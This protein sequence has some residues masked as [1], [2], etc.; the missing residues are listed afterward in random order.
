MSFVRYIFYFIILTITLVF[1]STFFELIQLVGIKPNA[2]LITVMSIAYIR[3]EKEGFI[4]GFTAGLMQDCFF[5]TYVGSNVFL[6][7]LLGYFGGILCKSFYKEN[8]FIAVG[9]IMAAS[10][11]Y[12]FSYYVIN[13]LLR[14][15]TDLAYFMEKLI[16]PEAV[17]DGLAALLL[18]NILFTFNEWLEDRER[19]KRKVF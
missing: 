15:Y 8:F 17:Y 4:T 1:Q 5:C 6:Y 10:I 12:N 14:G 3:G 9:V 16:I 7:S 19:Y 11:A 2:M 13:I 18:Y